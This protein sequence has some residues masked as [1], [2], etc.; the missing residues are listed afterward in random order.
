MIP[1][2]V[3]VPVYN[4]SGFM[5]RCVDSIINQLCIWENAKNNL[6]FRPN[7]VHTSPLLSE[8]LLD[9]NFNDLGGTGF[10]Q[11]SLSQVAQGFH[12]EFSFI[13]TIFDY[14]SDK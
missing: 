3:I 7:A 9:G 10:K 6:K 8:R 5:S 13:S 11:R 4:V 2:S 1:V 12:W 14:S